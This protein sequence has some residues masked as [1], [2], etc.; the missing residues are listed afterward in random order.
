MTPISLYIRRNRI[1]QYLKIFAQ[2]RTLALRR[3]DARGLAPAAPSVGSLKRVVF[4]GKPCQIDGSDLLYIQIRGIFG[5]LYPQSKRNPHG[6]RVS[7]GF[8]LKV[9]S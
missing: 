7:T 5:V 1:F 2:A 9:S 6:V 4:S 8:S 3:L